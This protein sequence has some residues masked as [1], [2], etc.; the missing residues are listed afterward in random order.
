MAWM[1]EKSL[2]V[3]CSMRG[4][5]KMTQEAV[6]GKWLEV[7]NHLQLT[8]AWGQGLCLL[9]QYPQQLA[10]SCHSVSAC[11][12]NEWMKENRILVDIF[13]RNDIVEKENFC[14]HIWRVHLWT[15]EATG[16]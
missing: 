4:G 15:C 6:A 16:Q 7:G 11:L 8:A 14:E 5:R 13:T 2:A 12:M 3:L 9:S 1:P 10:C